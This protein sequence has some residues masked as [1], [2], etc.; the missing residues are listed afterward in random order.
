[1]RDYCGKG[2]EDEQ[3]ALMPLEKY[4]PEH[5]S[6]ISGG[7]VRPVP[8]SNYRRR[9]TKFTYRN[10]PVDGNRVR[11]IKFLVSRMSPSALSK[12]LP[13]LKK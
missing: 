1:M 7:R 8:L 6:G 2:V 11:E 4:V 13:L 10:Y 12:S 9:V 3:R 5:I